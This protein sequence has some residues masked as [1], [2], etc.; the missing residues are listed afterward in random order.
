MQPKKQPLI[1][2]EGKDCGYCLG[3]G[4][5]YENPTSQKRTIVCLECNKGKSPTKL[6][7][8]AEEFKRCDRWINRNIKHLSDCNCKGTSYLLPKK[9]ELMKLGKQK[10]RPLSNEIV[11]S[12]DTNRK[13]E[14]ASAL[15]FCLSS[16]AVL[17]RS[18][19]VPEL[20]KIKTPDE[21]VICEGHYE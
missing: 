21:I 11:S 15:K 17:K 18:Y 14:D 7:F 9:W 5:R 4:L 2:I 1:A 6:I 8:N 10:G 19:E 16:D 13:F 3:T 20:Y 12:L